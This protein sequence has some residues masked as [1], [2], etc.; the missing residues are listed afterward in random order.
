MVFRSSW[1]L[2]LKNSKIENLG[3]NCTFCVQIALAFFIAIQCMAVH[4]SFCVFGGGG[5]ENLKK[6]IIFGKFK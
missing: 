5:S 4:L 1:R 2:F 3:Q 6:M